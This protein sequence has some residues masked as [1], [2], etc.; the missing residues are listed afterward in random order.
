MDRQSDKLAATFLEHVVNTAFTRDD[1]SW[2]HLKEESR[3]MPTEK[4]VALG[5]HYEV[6]Q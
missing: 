1:G 5:Q 3:P 4:P 2:D 6:R